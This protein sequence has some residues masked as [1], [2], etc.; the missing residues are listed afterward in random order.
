MRRLN[1]FLE[2]FPPSL[3]NYF[4]IYLSVSFCIFLPSS[5]IPTSLAIR[6]I[7]VHTLM[8]LWDSFITLGTVQLYTPM[9]TIS[10]LCSIFLLL[11]MLRQHSSVFESTSWILK[12]AMVFADQQE[13]KP[14]LLNFPFRIEIPPKF[15]TLYKILTDD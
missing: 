1:F 12:I 11:M 3:F 15:N 13:I 10:P 5:S 8:K 9:G 6:N 7:L 2:F 14:G 4:S